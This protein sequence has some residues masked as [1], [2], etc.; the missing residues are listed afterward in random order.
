MEMNKNM[1]PDELMNLVSGGV[2]PENWE[3][4]ADSLAGSFKMMYPNA[5]YEEALEILKT[6]CT[7][8]EDYQ[9]IAEYMKKYF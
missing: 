5:T 7:D 4:I 9:K 1:L 2:L 8:P 3:Q 6:Y